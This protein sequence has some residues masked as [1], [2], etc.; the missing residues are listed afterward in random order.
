MQPIIFLIMRSYVE[1][2][3]ATLPKN[4]KIVVKFKIIVKYTIKIV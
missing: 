1:V 2:N 3:L 4:F